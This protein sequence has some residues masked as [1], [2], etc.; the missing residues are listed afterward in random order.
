VRIP[1]RVAANVRGVPA[2]EQWV[3]QLPDTVRELADRWD[4]QLGEPFEP[5]GECS[6]VAPVERFGQSLV[7]K[8]GWRHPEADHEADALR[9][10]AGDGAVG[11]VD[12][13]Q[14]D[15]SSVLLLERCR[16][17]T[18]LKG[19]PEPE[20]DE[21]I[22][23]LLG[24]LW[25]RVQPAEPFRPLVEMCE[26]WAEESVRSTSSTIVAEGA[27][28][29]RELSRQ[30]D[31][32]VL[33]V[34]DLHADNVLAAERE[35]WLVIDPKPYVG[36]PAYDVVQHMLNCEE[37]LAADPVALAHRMADL[38]GLDRQRVVSWLF[39]RCAMAAERDPACAAVADCL[40]RSIG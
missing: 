40:A 25:R 34:T 24:R 12:T 26:Q 36:D 21:V 10:W 22:A 5:G 19:R 16:P 31:Q 37:R 20:Q 30:T 18:T 13:V 7:L 1:E 6:W 11:L 38:A 15:Q 29:F 9:L 23:E 39:A 27:E 2:L 14:T 33:L 4:L 8:V 17:G 35:P 3:A 28:L 32:S